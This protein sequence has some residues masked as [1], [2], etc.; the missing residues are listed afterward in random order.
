VVDRAWG[1]VSE[2]PA[3]VSLWPPTTIEAR[4][5]LF[6]T[7]AN[8]FRRTK[9]KN[10]QSSSGAQTRED[11]VFANALLWGERVMVS[12]RLPRSTRMSRAICPLPHRPCWTSCDISTWPRCTPPCVS[13][14]TTIRTS[15]LIL[16]V[17]LWGTQRD[18][19]RASNQYSP[20]A[21]I[22]AR[23]I[24]DATVAAETK[25]LAEKKAGTRLMDDDDV[26]TLVPVQK[27]AQPDHRRKE[28]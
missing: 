24:Q 12:A 14:R 2:R 3:G 16:R 23:R 17:S 11:Q 7:K 4:D 19:V 6:A 9:D 22:H 13:M 8:L 18:S 20:S 21:Q 25:A 1:A 5:Q 26:N 27:A 28:G 10:G 15:W